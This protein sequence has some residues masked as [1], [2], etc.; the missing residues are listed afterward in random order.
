MLMTTIAFMMGIFRIVPAFRDSGFF[1]LHMALTIGATYLAEQKF[2]ARGIE[3]AMFSKAA[4]YYFAFFHLI[5]INIVTFMAYG[6]DK[7]KAIKGQDRVKE[8]VLFSLGIFG[9]TPLA[10]VAQIFFHHK[11]KKKEFQGIFITIFILQMIAIIGLLKM[12][13]F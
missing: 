11:T 8:S 10:F 4:L 3:I 12:M 6:I 7:S 5:M 2:A 1:V 9:G 13:G